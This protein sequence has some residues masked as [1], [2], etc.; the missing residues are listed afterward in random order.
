MGNLNLDFSDVKTFDKVDEGDHVF[1]VE[2]A[3]VKPAKSGETDNLVITASVV[4]GSNDGR[5]LKQ[6]FNLGPN[7]LWN[8]KLFL[9][10]V[11]GETLTS[12]SLD[13]D[14]LVGQTFVG[15]V[16]HSEDGKYANLSAFESNS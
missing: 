15:T 4:G 16:Q 10:A 7:A 8:A 13:T 14:D 11:H 6:F 2:E 5:S 1:I 3:E 12:V 9:E